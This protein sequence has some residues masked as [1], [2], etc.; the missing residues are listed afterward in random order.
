[1]D[2][3]EDVVR[4]VAKLSRLAVGDDEAH[5]LAEQLSDIISYAK[6]L[7]SV[8]L[9]DVPPTSHAFQLTNVLRADTPHPG[10]TQAQAL[11]NAP[12]SDGQHVRVPAVL[13]G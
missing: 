10:L 2:I 3:T 5:E 8:D 1:L 12:D 6:Q 9:S 7:Q 11:A 4:H 13:E